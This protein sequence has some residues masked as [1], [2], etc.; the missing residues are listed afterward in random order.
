MDSI[1][2]IESSAYSEAFVFCEYPS[3]TGKDRVDIV[4][5]DE[6]NGLAVFIEN[7]YGA[8][9]SKGQLRKYY[10]H[11]N[12]PFKQ[13]KFSNIFI[14]LDDTEEHIEENW[15]HIDYEWLYSF[16]K[17][18]IKHKSISGPAL[19]IVKDFL[20]Y[21]E[22]YTLDERYGE[23]W[24]TLKR[25][26][27]TH[28]NFLND[29]REYK[30]EEGKAITEVVYTDILATE[31]AS[32]H[33]LAF[34]AYQSYIGVINTLLGMSEWDP[35]YE[36]AIQRTGNESLVDQK[37]LRFFFTTNE[38]NSLTERGRF[39]YWPVEVGIEKKATTYETFIKVHHALRKLFEDEINAAYNDLRERNYY[40]IQKTETPAED[41]KLTTLKALRLYDLLEER[42]AGQLDAKNN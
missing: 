28:R 4:L 25:L 30:S 16:L 3:P 14:Y 22:D 32:Y 17:C 39:D 7:K 12:T 33:Y 24:K 13:Q 36:A 41:I 26:Y 10:D 38:A 11:F 34:K 29:L 35:I 2:S 19:R 5:I 1:F 6:T 27:R 15:I 21:T 42:T 23:S 8:K 37:K 20:Y 40:V 9:L 31:Y 18:A